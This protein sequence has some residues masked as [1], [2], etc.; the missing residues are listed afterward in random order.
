MAG[1]VVG[2]S[3]VPD[4]SGGAFSPVLRDSAAGA[5]IGSVVPGLNGSAFCLTLNGDVEP[6]GTVSGLAEDVLIMDLHLWEKQVQRE[7]R[8]TGADGSQHSFRADC[9][10]S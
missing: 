6:D 9:S 2:A 3:T 7:Q 10:V 5:P 1:V 8:V 4:L